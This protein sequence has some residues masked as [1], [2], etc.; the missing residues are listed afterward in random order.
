MS[1]GVIIICPGCKFACFPLK[2]ERVHEGQH[3]C[4]GC[5]AVA[6]F[7][8]VRRIYPKPETVRFDIIWE[9]PPPLD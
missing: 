7:L 1:I 6:T 2:A 4:R 3:T 9:L 5:G 8:E